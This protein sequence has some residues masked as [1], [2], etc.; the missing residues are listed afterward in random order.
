M[1]T[2]ETIVC[3]AAADWHGMWARAQQ[4]MTVYARHNNRVL[5]IDPPITLLSPIKNP[6]LRRRL[7]ARVDQV[8]ENI[9]VYRP[10]VMLP[11]GNMRRWVN[12]LNQQRLGRA[13]IKELRKLG[14]SPT[15]FWTYLPNS[16][17]LLPVFGGDVPV[18]Y[19][20]ADEHTAFPGL[21]DVKT[22][23]T[24]EREL[25]SRADASLV[26]A[27]ELWERKKACA[28][29]L[30]LIP[31]GAEVKHFGQAM[32][33]TLPVAREVAELPGP[34]VGYVGAVSSWLDQESLAA[35]AGAHP[36]WSI[37]LIGPVDTDVSLLRGYKN[38][39]LPGKKDYRE[40]PRYLKAFNVCVIPF[41]LNE[42]TV[43][44]NPVK[45]YEYLAAGKP[46][47]STALPE[48][49][50]FAPLVGIAENTAQFVELVTEAV[51]NDSKAEAARR[52]QVARENSWEAR[53]EAAA[54]KLAACRKP[55]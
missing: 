20:C 28:P 13:L 16:V 46:V 26:T 14:W 37:V 25:F 5:Y 35:L 2:G 32:E 53:A 48:V 3:A 12:R 36:D 34:V 38:I 24:M 50:E 19:D 45:L 43:N 51:K 9:F 55:R 21:I 8:G 31:N 40:L 1:L 27:R 42:L 15:L 39:Y 17:D 10:P 18:C 33:E 4:L 30:T 52:V 44:V 11:F 49:R 47:V 54:R 7:S 41:K 22:V 29:G 6:E 23:S